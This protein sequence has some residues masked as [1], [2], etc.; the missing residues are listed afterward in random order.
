MK[1]IHIV[2]ETEGFEKYTGFNISGRP[3]VASLKDD[4][5]GTTEVVR[6]D[7]QVAKSNFLSQFT[8]EEEK[9]IKRKIDRRFL[10]LIGLMYMIKTVRVWK[11]L[12]ELVA[13]LIV[14]MCRSTS[15]MLL[16][17]KYYRS[18][19]RAIYSLSYI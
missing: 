12:R 6:R 15:A 18:A 4:E 16:A 14:F 8:P 9:R 2:P 13:F 17:S 19:S 7:N 10:L 11:Y 1:G 5:Q 3:D